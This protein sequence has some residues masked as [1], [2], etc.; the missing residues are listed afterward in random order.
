MLTGKEVRRLYQ[1]LYRKWRPQVFA[2][3]VGQ[4]QVTITLKNELMAG[5]IAH[6]YLFTGSRGTGKTTCAKILAKAVNCLTPVDGDPC[7]HCEICQGMDQGSVLDIV[8]IDAASNNGVENIRSLREEANFTPA[9]AKYRVYIIDEVHMLS[10]GAFNALLKTLEEPPAHVVFILATTEVHKL[11]ATI[12]SRCQRFDFRRIPPA[13]IA[14]RLEYVASQEGAALDGQAGLLLSRLADGALRDALS[15]LDQCIGVGKEITVSVVNQVVGI[16]GREP[17]F[18]LAQAVHEKN[19]AAALEIIDDLHGNSKDM[20]RLCEE[21]CSHFRSLMLIKTMKDAGEILVVTKEELEELTHQALPMELSFLLHALDVLQRTMEQMGR[22]SNQ[23]IELEMALIRLCTPELDTGNG[24]LIRRI[25]ALERKSL[26]NFQGNQPNLDTEKGNSFTKENTFTERE[27]VMGNDFTDKEKKEPAKRVSIPQV[28]RKPAAKLDSEAD[29][30]QS[31]PP[32]EPPP[33]EEIPAGE[34][35]G[36]PVPVLE[37][38]DLGAAPAA[39]PKRGESAPA[40]EELCANAVP[41]AEWPEVL[42]LLKE[43]SRPVSAAFQGSAAYCSGNYMLIDAKNSMAFELLRKEEQRQ[44]MRDTIRQVTGRDYK[45]GPYK[46][47]GEPSE[48]KEDPLEL[49]AKQAEAA[50]IPVIKK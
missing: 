35:A 10:V 19:A 39:K 3:V 2:D 45:L 32:P 31:L 48:F 16:A 24:A 8:E 26:G 12:L 34:M 7:G 37:N 47:P 30:A 27:F 4:P 18:Q 13:E 49:L 6:A 46:R 40:L 20:M 9:V 42:Q 50:G 38:P 22:G 21:L 5:R 14:E 41:F 11:P 44:K 33:M 29:I 36:E 25:E 23:R 15:L 17:L 28:K 1:V 43:Y